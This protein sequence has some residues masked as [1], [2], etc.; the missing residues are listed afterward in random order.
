M[1]KKIALFLTLCST[2]IGLGQSCPSLI[3]PLDGATNVPVDATIVWNAVAGIPGYQIRL[4]TAPGLGDIAQASVGS[5]TAYTPPRGMPENTEVFV[6]IVLDFLFQGGDDIICQG[7]SFFTEDVVTP[8]SCTNIRTPV[9]NATDVSVFTNISWDYAPRAT[10]Y[11]VALGTSPGGNEIFPL[12]DVGNVLTFNPPGQLPPNQDIY[13]RII[14]Y[15]ENGDAVNCEEYEFT[16]RDVAPLPGCTSLIS[17]ANGEVNVPLTPFIE[18]VEVPEATGYRVTIGTTPDGNDIL[19]EASF[20][21]NSTF[22]IDFDENRTFFITIVPF[23]PSGSA[24]GCP[25]ESFSTALGCGPFLDLTTGDFVDLFPDIEFPTVFSFCKNNEPLVLEAPPGADG[26]RWVSV[27]QFGN[28]TIL[29]EGNQVTITENGTF[30][31]EAFNF[32]PQAEGVLECPVILDFEVVSS[33]TPRIDNLRVRETALGLD[34]TV[35]VSGSGDY[36]Y[37]INNIDGPYQDSN[38]FSGVTPGTSTFYVRDKGGCGIVEETL[39]QDLTVEGFP[40]FFTPNGDTIND[41][42]QFIQPKTGEQIVLQSIQ[43][44]D[45]YGMFLKQIDQNSL[46][47]DGT[48]NGNPL[49]SGDY[50]FKAVDNQNRMVQGHFALKR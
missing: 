23:N 43:I 29:E 39:V 30:F 4:G 31:L 15:N 25:Q 10:G 34:V 48:F 36:E 35:E 26:Y 32:S 14:P 8:P 11:R 42:W 12:Q 28:N 9:D 20:F 1:L 18:W 3:T 22:V 13:V 50:W 17:P 7:Q 45:R 40:K 19:D 47:W 37:A 44:F 49:P 21:T 41:F 33:E 27:D 6:T 16:T 38:Q 46:G 5:S 2:A 24:I